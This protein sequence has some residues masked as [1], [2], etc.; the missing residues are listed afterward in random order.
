MAEF[1][2]GPKVVAACWNLLFERNMI[3]VNC[4][5]KPFLWF[6]AHSRTYTAYEL[7]CTKFGTSK[8]NF[9]EKVHAMSTAIAELK[10]YIFFN[11][12]FLL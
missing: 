2:F 9:V 6:L 4:S 11:Y 1:G 5:C 3:P 12:L 7:Y 8:P 10:E